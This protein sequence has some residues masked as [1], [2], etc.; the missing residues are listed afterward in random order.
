[1]CE[2]N[3]IV[4]VTAPCR[5]HFG[6]LAFGRDSGRQYGG[7]GVMIDKPAIRVRIS[8]S[9]RLSTSGPAAHRAEHFARAWNRS[10]GLSGQPCCR[11]EITSAAAQ[12]SGLGVGTQL[13]LSVAAGLNAWHGR[14]QPSP[15]ELAISVG[16]GL[17]S[18]VGTY[19]FA[20][21][22]LI[23]DRGKLPGE[24]IA[25]LDCRLPLPENWRF[26][27]IQPRTGGGLSGTAEHRAFSQLPA[28]PEDVSA[29]L[30]EEIRAQ[31]VPAVVEEDFERFSESVYRYGRLAGLCFAAVQG[32]PYNGPHLAELVDHVRSLGVAG[33]GQSSWGPTLF[34]IVENESQAASLIDRLRAGSLAGSA[35]LSVSAANNCGARIVRF[36]NDGSNRG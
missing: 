15:A 26:V 16:R 6:L 13:G 20:E 36:A 30:R 14:A 11:I 28:V 25:P 19:G 4:A 12:H 5:L 10:S 2:A 9:E 18:A 22:G 34:A 33:V 24:S 8:P 32:G 1:M 7:V 31:M 35:E 21:G 17:R 3:R 29:E 23:V 27:L